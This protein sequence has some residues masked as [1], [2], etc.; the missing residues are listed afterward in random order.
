MKHMKRLFILGSMISVLTLA[1]PDRVIAGN[2][3][4]YVL[5]QQTPPIAP[6]PMTL[7]G[8]VKILKHS[9]VLTLLFAGPRILAKWKL[10]QIQRQEEEKKLKSSSK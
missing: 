1:L 6:Y 7:E 2:S 3:Q 5:A 4:V 10:N 8:F 9:A